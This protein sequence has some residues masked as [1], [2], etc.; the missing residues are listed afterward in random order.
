MKASPEYNTNEIQIITNHCSWQEVKIHSSKT[1][2]INKLARRYTSQEAIRDAITRPLP[3]IPAPS[4]VESHKAKQHL[5]QH[6]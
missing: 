1:V 4:R 5:Q 2:E 3:P 6:F